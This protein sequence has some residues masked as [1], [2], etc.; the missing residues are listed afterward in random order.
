[1]GWAVLS[2]TDF[3]RLVPGEVL[4]T[5]QPSARAC[6][7]YLPLQIQHSLAQAMGRFRPAE[8]DSRDCQP[9][10]QED[11]LLISFKK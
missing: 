9:S 2:E 11:R 4:F 10:L 6:I 3:G 5:L 8:G 7:P 1:M